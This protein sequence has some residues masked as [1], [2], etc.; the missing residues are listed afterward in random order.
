MTI[1]V[2]KLGLESLKF[3]LKFKTRVTRK[4]SDEAAGARMGRERTM[5]V[6]AFYSL[7]S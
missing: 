7:K 2:V 1:G 4:I 5:R 6:E 3:S